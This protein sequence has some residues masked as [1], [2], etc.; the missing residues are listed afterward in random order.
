MLTL[1]RGFVRL[2]HFVIGTTTTMVRSRNRGLLKD[3]LRILHSVCGV[4]DVR[5]VV[6]QRQDIRS[7]TLC[8]VSRGRHVLFNP[9]HSLT[10]LLGAEFSERKVF[11]RVLWGVRVPMKTKGPVGSLDFVPFD[12]FEQYIIGMVGEGAKLV[13]QGCS[14]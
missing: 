2:D 4:L 3:H 5:L 13:V 11:V 10:P 6:R 1:E 7:S 14:S 9:Y 8:N 12:T